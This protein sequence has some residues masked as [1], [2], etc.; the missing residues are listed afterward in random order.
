[1]L[2]GEASI[3][4][5]ALHL[6]ASSLRSCVGLPLSCFFYV[7]GYRPLNAYGR[8]CSTTSTSSVQ[9][10][11]PVTV[12]NKPPHHHIV[13][14]ARAW[15]GIGK[16][17]LPPTDWPFLSSYPP[18]TSRM[19]YTASSASYVS[20]PLDVCRRHSL[21][22]GTRRCRLSGNVTMTDAT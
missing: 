22:Q 13:N 19:P 21:R 4:I 6:T 9:I 11:I 1:M 20:P 12:V 2:R 8:R 15:D 14:T 3:I 16:A 5:K 7:Y 17:S 10:L 18:E